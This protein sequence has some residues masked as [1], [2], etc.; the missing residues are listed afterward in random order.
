MRKKLNL[1][2]EER[3]IYNNE[4]HRKQNLARKQRNEREVYREIV[5][6]IFSIF[7]TLGW[8]RMDLV[9]GADMKMVEAVV[10]KLIEEDKFKVV[11]GAKKGLKLKEKNGKD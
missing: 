4:M 10:D 11:L 2:P 8:D 3:R 7:E 1:T 5:W 9:V 6:S